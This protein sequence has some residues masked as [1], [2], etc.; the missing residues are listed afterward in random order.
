MLSMGIGKACKK[1]QNSIE[2]LAIVAIGMGL[3]LAASVWGYG[4]YSGL[5]SQW[6]EKACENL[7]KSMA[8]AADGVSGG[9]SGTAYSMQVEFPEG[10]SSIGFNSNTV[11]IR[12]DTGDG[13][14]VDVNYKSAAKLS[15]SISPASGPHTLV[16]TSSGSSVLVSEGG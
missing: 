4:A 5:E 2:L 12:L 10:I 1:G 13:R 15:G 9:A 16:F 14:F 6:R 11:N 8:F 7:A 3:V